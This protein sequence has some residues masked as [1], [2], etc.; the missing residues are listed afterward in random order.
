LGPSDDPEE[1]RQCVE[2]VGLFSSQWPGWS[3]DADQTR[4]HIIDWWKAQG[5]FLVFY[6]AEPP[7]VPRFVGMQG[8]SAIVER[9][10]PFYRDG[11]DSRVE[12]RVTYRFR[13]VQ[14]PTIQDP[15]ELKRHHQWRIADICVYH[16]EKA[17]PQ[18][19]S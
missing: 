10:G 1:Q 18:P 5:G 12:K 15:P 6:A 11:T 9:S 13:L 14:D 19:E 16:T 17:P 7:S 8:D 4:R 2:Q 3:H